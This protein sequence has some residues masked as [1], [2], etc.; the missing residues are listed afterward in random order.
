[1]TKSAAGLAS[2]WAVIE[3]KT[4]NNFTTAILNTHE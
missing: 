3:V 2:K 4:D 1:M